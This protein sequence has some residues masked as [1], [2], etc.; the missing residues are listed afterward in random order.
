VRKLR[1][2]GECLRDESRGARKGLTGTLRLGVIAAAM[3]SISFLTER[4]CELHP[5][6]L[7]DI[8]SMTSRAVQQGLERF[9]LD[10]GLA[11]LDNEPLENVSRIPLYNERYVFVCQSDH[12]LADLETVTWARAVKEPLCLP[13]EDMQS[14]RILNDIAASVELKITPSIASN[15][16][17]GVCAH[18]R[19]GMWCGIVPHS[20]LYV[21]GGS[22]GL[23]SIDL[24]APRRSHTIGLVLPSRVSQSPMAVA[25]MGALQGADF[26][27]RFRSAMGS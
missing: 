5:D 12:P 14:R 15:S 2:L 7:V 1:P 19:N 22:S 23:V 3:P 9:E 16:F 11:Y 21:F 13:S 8:R 24:V 20:F 18:L 27:A 10:G 17:L 4:F 6:A 25:L 26:G